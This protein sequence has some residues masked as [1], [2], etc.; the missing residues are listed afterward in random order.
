MNF[1]YSRLIYSKLVRLVL[2]DKTRKP[3]TSRFHVICR[4]H[5]I[6]P[7]PIFRCHLLS[8]GIVSRFVTIYAKIRVT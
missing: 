8:L 6:F 3:H 1:N 2:L 5:Q 7:E 4:C